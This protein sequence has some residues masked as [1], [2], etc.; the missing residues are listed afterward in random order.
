VALPDGRPGTIRGDATDVFGEPE[1]GG[2]ATVLTSEGM[3]RLRWLT[4]RLAGEMS[5]RIRK[6][7]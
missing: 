3:R 7:K 1:T 2:V 4:E 6:R 5:G